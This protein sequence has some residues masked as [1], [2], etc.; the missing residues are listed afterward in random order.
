MVPNFKLWLGAYKLKRDLPIIPIAG[1]DIILGKD[2]LGETNPGIDWST[3]RVVVK[4]GANSECI[5]PLAPQYG[6]EGSHVMLMSAS[7][8]AR[9]LNKGSYA[10]SFIALVH[11]KE[12]G[13]GDLELHPEDEPFGPSPKYVGGTT[14]FKSKVNQLVTKYDAIMHG[15]PPGLPPS[16]FEKD[17]T[18]GLVEGAKPPYGPLYRMSPAELEEVRRQLEDLLAKGWIRPSESPYGAPILFVRKKDGSLRMAVDYRRLNALTK[19]NRTPVSSGDCTADP[20]AAPVL[21]EAQQV[22]IWLGPSGLPG[23]RHLSSRHQCGP[24]QDPGH[25]RLAYPNQPTGC[26]TL[27]GACWLLQA[28]CGTLR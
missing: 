28:V 6:G 12:T 11:E 19:K 1:Y 21:L 23:T 18:I 5:L 3:N 22:P 20:A 14:T 2:W 27:P 8:A 26:E 4:T 7:A 17:F 9:V 13:E 24:S 16:R 25:P 10:V 15:P